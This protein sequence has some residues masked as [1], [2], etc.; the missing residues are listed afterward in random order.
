MCLTCC[1][2]RRGQGLL[3]DEHQLRH[4]LREGKE[5]S[6]PPRPHVYERNGTLY[7]DVILK[8]EDEASLTTTTAHHTQR[9]GGIVNPASL[10][11]NT[12][13]LLTPRQGYLA[14]AYGKSC[15]M[16]MVRPP[17]CRVKC[18]VREDNDA[19]SLLRRQIQLQCRFALKGKDALPSH[20]THRT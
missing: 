6:L 9:W 7:A 4:I 2:Q 14:F 1:T 13:P 8:G 20:M 10:S 17:C 5:A 3:A 15:S 11:M 19:S 16:I 12:T 18:I